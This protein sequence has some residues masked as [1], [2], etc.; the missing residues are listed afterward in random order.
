MWQV[1]GRREIHTFWWTDMKE[2]DDLEDTKVDEWIKLKRILN[3]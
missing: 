1:W 3:K 2:I